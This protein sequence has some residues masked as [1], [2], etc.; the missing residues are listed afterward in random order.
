MFKSLQGFN[1]SRVKAQSM[2]SMSNLQLICQNCRTSAISIS[3]SAAVIAKIHF[4]SWNSFQFIANLIQAYLYQIRFSNIYIYIYIYINP[5]V[6]IHSTTNVITCLKLCLNQKWWLTKGKTEMKREH[7]T[8][9]LNWSSC[10]KLAPKA[11]WTHCLI[12]QS[13]RTSER[14]SAVVGSNPIQ[15]NFL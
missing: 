5:Y 6:S 1:N 8:K 15:A 13:V 2:F 9:R 10:T 12:A 4:N 3:Y 11:S 7:K 14:N